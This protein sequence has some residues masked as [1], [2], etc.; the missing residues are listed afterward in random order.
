MQYHNCQLADIDIEGI[1]LDVYSID[2]YISRPVK[3]LMNSFDPVE[4]KM[5]DDYR[6]A[7][8]NVALSTPFPHYGYHE[9]LGQILRVG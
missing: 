1:I 2:E 6:I 4:I 9:R 7:L 8:T 5:L 3:Y